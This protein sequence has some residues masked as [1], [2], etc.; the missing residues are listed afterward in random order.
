VP[1]VVRNLRDEEV[2]EIGVMEN[3]EGENVNGMEV[4]V[5]YQGLMDELGLSEEEVSVKVGKC[6]WDMANLLR[7]LCLGDEVKDDV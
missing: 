2:M 3:V 6:G 4:G 5:G 7:L 1:A